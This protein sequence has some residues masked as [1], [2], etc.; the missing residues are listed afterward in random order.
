M[1]IVF[2]LAPFLLTLAG[3]PA[4]AD[5]IV[6]VRPGAEGEDSSPY[7]FFPAL[8]R[9]SYDTLYA[10]VAS[11]ENGADHSMQTFLRFELPAGL[12]GPSERIVSAQL[13]VTYAF[14]FD[15]YGNVNDE[16]GNLRCHVVTQP[17]NE[18][19]LTW[20]NRPA[21]EPPFHVLDGIT[22]F[23]T[24]GFDVTAQVSGWVTGALPNFGLALTSTTERV[25]GFYSFERSGVD[26]NVKPY[27]VVRIGPSALPDAD[28]DGVADAADNC[29]QSPNAAQADEDLDGVGD[30]CDDCTR[31]ANADQRDVDADGFGNA[32]D[33]DLD[34]NGIVNFADLA[35]LKRAF[36]TTGP[37]LAADLD[38]NG[39]VNFADLARLKQSFFGP[40]GPSGVAP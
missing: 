3:T 32:C 10:F 20:L 13:R 39:V 26:P 37:D 9:G 18:A 22:S 23:R 34:Q 19:S 5:R 25:L 2:L 7:G 27:L 30:A 17:W 33:A 38:G 21:F 36:F 6:T 8:A 14:D 24:L 29:P 4:L 35:Q 40:P 28:S 1:R 16:A 11:G 31:V 12:L 15:Q